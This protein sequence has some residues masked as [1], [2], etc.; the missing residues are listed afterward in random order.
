MR[1]DMIVAHPT[2]PTQANS[3]ESR[4]TLYPT[5]TQ[6]ARYVYSLIHHLKRDCTSITRGGGKGP[7]IHNNQS[8]TAL[9]IAHVAHRMG[10]P[11]KSGRSAVATL[12]RKYRKKGQETVH[13]T[14]PKS[15]DSFHHCSTSGIPHPH[16]RE[17]NRG[18]GPHRNTRRILF[19]PKKQG[20]VGMNQHHM[21]LR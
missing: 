15:C 6:E 13:T 2:R 10:A 11:T 14:I 12:A 3:P 8:S 4:Y 5:I 7:Y 20:D 16:V 18:V 1:G 9:L 21:S 17:G 19:L